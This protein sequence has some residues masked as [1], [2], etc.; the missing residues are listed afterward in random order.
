MND[1]ARLRARPATG[2]ATRP[3]ARG[4]AGGPAQ[5]RSALERVSAAD[6][7]AGVQQ[8]LGALIGAVALAGLLVFAPGCGVESH[9]DQKGRDSVFQDQRSDIVRPTRK[10]E[11]VDP[12]SWTWPREGAHRAR[13]EVE[14]HG[15][16][17]IEL[18]PALAPRNVANFEKLASAGYYDGT[19]FHRVIEGFMVQGG[20][21]NTRD[22][23]PRND[24]RGDP[25]YS[26]P[27]E[28]SDAP[29]V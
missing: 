29:H 10:P 17:E 4:P 6:A 13:I 12:S 27:D 2:P 15:A 18:Y 28:F 19:T 3:M 5:L 26:V 24:G 9:R 16:I 20:D 8:T 14:G 7:A 22:A 1:T 25:G 23:N 11:P 21:A